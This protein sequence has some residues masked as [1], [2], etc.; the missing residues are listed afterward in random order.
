M[1]V[2]VSFLN[3]RS[4]S[5]RSF[6]QLFNRE[7]RRLVPRSVK[8]SKGFLGQLNIRLMCNNPGS[9]HALVIQSTELPVLHIEDV[10]GCEAIEEHFSLQLLI[11]SF[12]LPK[13]RK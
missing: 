6:I 7:L 3:F 11:R 10:S 13:L 8:L 2:R 1:F 12:P 5:F 4:Q 9:S